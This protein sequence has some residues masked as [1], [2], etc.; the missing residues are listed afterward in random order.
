MRE[1]APELENRVVGMSYD[2][3]FKYAVAISWNENENRAVVEYATVT[4]GV[5]GKFG[6]ISEGFTFDFTNTY[7]SD[8]SVELELSGN[9]TL[10]G[11]DV[12]E[13]EFSFSIYEANSSFTK[14]NLIRTV[15]NKGG[16]I[17]FGAISFSA[18]GVYYM[19]ANENATSI[20]GITIDTTEYHI[21]VSVEK[22]IDADG[23]TRLKISR[24]YPVV[25]A[26]GSTVNVGATG[27]DFNNVYTVTGS[28]D[29]IIKG[30]KTLIGRPLREGE[31][32]FGLYADA[33]CT[34]LIESVTNKADGTF[35]FSP[36]TFTPDYL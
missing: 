32:V 22:F 26:N 21:T 36:I 11:A 12:G 24:A 17:D 30:V 27:L 15:T 29:V 20:G 31:F 5:V 9:K 35:A 10:N 28:E 16:L 7:E 23:T 1:V 25:V 14:G 6:S 34:I 4:D 19:V 18:A 33:D 13:L 8:I 3:E 2:D